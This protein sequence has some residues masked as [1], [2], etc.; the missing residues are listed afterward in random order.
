MSELLA[1][2]WRTPIKSGRTTK[3]AYL[4][5]FD[6]GI[7]ANVVLFVDKFKLQLP[8]WVL[9]DFLSLAVVV[10]PEAAINRR[11][12][13]ERVEIKDVMA[14][15]LAAAGFR[16]N[17]GRAHTY[18][19]DSRTDPN[20][21]LESRGKMDE[22]RTTPEPESRAERARRGDHNEMYR[23]IRKDIE[24]AKRGGA[25]LTKWSGIDEVMKCAGWTLYEVIS[26][27]WV[28]NAT[29]ERNMLRAQVVKHRKEA[30]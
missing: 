15:R 11:A 30:R 19:P 17:P 28:R 5:I 16:Y 25:D 9:R 4:D 29:R 3:T 27:I 1:S 20:T 18:L 14:D 12:H 7:S 6:N 22:T 26:A 2:Y 8:K 23:M 13:P 24:E 10:Y 21:V